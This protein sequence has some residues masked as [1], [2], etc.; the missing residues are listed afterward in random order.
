MTRLR[1]GWEMGQNSKL[2]YDKTD[3]ISIFKYALPLLNHTLRDIVGNDAI[4]GYSLDN[5]GKG[6]L[7]QMVEKLY[8]LYEPNSS[9][10]PD[11]KEAGVE[12]KTTGL[13]KLKDLSLQIKERLVIDMINYNEVVN[14]SF[15]V[16]VFYK[17]CRLLLLLFYLYQKGIEQYDYVFLLAALW[18]IPEKDLLIIKHDYQ[19]IIDKIKRG[20]AHLL[21]E[22]DTEYL[23]ACRKGQ[24]GDSL[25]EQPY[26]DIGAPRRAFSLKPSY[27]RTVLEYIK[28]SGK[29]S[30]INFDYKVKDSQIVTTKE[31]QEK[32]FED[33]I[34][35]RINPYKGKTYNQLCTA[36]NK[37]YDS[38]KSK[39]AALASR[40]ITGNSINVN[41]TEEFKKAGLQLK[42]IR[43]QQNGKIK[44][45]MSFENIDYHEVYETENWEDSRLYEIYSGRFLFVIFKADGN[46]IRYFNSKKNSYTEEDSYSLV[47]AFFW[48]MPTHDLKLAENYWQGIKKAVLDNHIAP[49]FFPKN[50]RFH[51]RPKGRDSK[52]LVD[53]PN[54]GQV[55]KYCYWF[56]NDYVR[57]IV[58]NNAT[59]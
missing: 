6:N 18:K 31:L 17:K 45:A 49:E 22:G 38:S 44:E 37:R 15:E 11:F 10:E 20:E 41:K 28:K 23:G 25:R 24:K 42:T 52:D 33:V 16:S 54:G 34:L 9:I 50:E 5:H 56:N 27:M 29:S 21:S 39:Y 40:I 46:T 3:A 53:N 32:S 2:P 13:K 4:A 12:L 51:V 43:V 1:C 58:R 47:D 30:V 55:K 48:T 57:E 36:L 59:E 7:G 26:S 19:V 35:Q 8:Y 14:Q